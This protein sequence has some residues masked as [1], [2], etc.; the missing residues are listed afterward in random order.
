M[1]ILDEGSGKSLENITLYLTALE[2][3]ELRDGLNSLLA[4]PLG[5]HVHISSSDYKKEVT[6]CVYDVN[7]LSGFNKRSIE[8]IRNE[9]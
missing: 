5:N 1:R 7:N 9:E 4:K 2:A 6:V 8:L 3:S